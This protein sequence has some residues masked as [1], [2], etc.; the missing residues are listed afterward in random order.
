M[1]LRNQYDILDSVCISYFSIRDRRE[2]TMLES[3]LVKSKVSK[4]CSQVGGG[5]ILTQMPGVS[6][7][8]N[9]GEVGIVIAMLRC[10]R[11]TYNFL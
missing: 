3:V 4:K 11:E 1:A 8:A 9:D 5:G 6:N 2:I 7:T 10:E